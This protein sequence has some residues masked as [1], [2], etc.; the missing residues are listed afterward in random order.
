MVVVVGWTP[1]RVPRNGAGGRPRGAGVV[2]CIR[3]RRRLRPW[4]R[5]DVVLARRRTRRTRFGLR[6]GQGFDP[7]ANRRELLLFERPA[8]RHRVTVDLSPDELGPQVALV[9]AS[10]RYQ[11]PA[12]GHRRGRQ[13]R[14]WI[15]V[16]GQSFGGFRVPTAVMAHRALV[17]EDRTY[18]L[19]LRG[20]IDTLW[21]G[22]D[23]HGS[24]Q[25]SEH[26]DVAPIGIRYG[27]TMRPGAPCTPCWV[28]QALQSPDGAGIGIARSASPWTTLT[29]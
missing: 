21:R 9:Q 7:S 24:Q 22:R 28:W 3:R 12:G 2:L 6:G 17:L 8:D 1:C 10:R 14:C 5:H 27:S 4:W 18:G 19:G 23:P 13:Q 11:G 15:P 16:E 25:Q 20:A 29:R 26:D